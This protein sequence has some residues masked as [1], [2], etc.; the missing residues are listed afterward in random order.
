MVNDRACGAGVE[1]FQ[2]TAEWPLSEPHRGAPRLLVHGMAFDCEEWMLEI[3]LAE[4]GDEIHRFIVVEGAF[5]LQNTPREQCFPRIAADNPH[6]ARWMHKI[7]YV[8]DTDAIPGFRYWEAEVYYRDLIGLKGLPQVP[9]LRKDDL[10]LI[11]DVDEI[12]S[13][14]FL[15]FLRFLPHGHPTLMRVEFLWTYYSFAWV[16]PRSH[17]VNAIA[18]VGELRALGGDH[19]NAVR[20]DLLGGGAAWRWTPAHGRLVGWHCSWCMPTEAFLSKRRH[21][22]HS[23]LNTPKHSS[24]DY[25]QRMRRKGLWFAG[26]EPNGCLQM[27]QPLQ[28]PKHVLEHRARFRLLIEPR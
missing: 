19:T 24:L 11:G 7:V 16:N 14:Q 1:A 13:R 10:V 12:F 17:G 18:S 25:L 4:M 27:R 5:S 20:F 28:A 8:F 3:K 26:E 22:A 6:I 15:R 2:V 21:F 23:E 9:G